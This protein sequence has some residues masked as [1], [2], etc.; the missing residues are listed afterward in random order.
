MPISEKE[1]WYDKRPLRCSPTWKTI[2]T[3]IVIAILAF[4]FFKVC[5]VENMHRHCYTDNQKL[6]TSPYYRMA[7]EPGDDTVTLLQRVENGIRLPEENV[8]W[9]RVF[10]ISAILGLVT[11]AVY[12]R[13][14]PNIVEYLVASALI[15]LILTAIT[16]WYEMH[17]W[18]RVRE[19]QLRTVDQLRVN[20]GVIKESDKCGIYGPSDTKGVT[21]VSC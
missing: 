12:K 19:Q 4:I 3:V 18:Y 1:A 8:N 17:I 16:N 15:Y 11:A 2:L 9:R 13:G 6:C 21:Y 7:P 14:L 5:K 20:L 10:M